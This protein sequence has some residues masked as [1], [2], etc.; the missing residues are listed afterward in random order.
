MNLQN[1]NIARIRWALLGIVVLV[2]M[3]YAM[4]GFGFYGYVQSWGGVVFKAICGGCIGWFISR[5]VIGL[6][7]SELPAEQRPMAGL[8]LAVLIGFFAHALSTGA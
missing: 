5:Y 7:I 6:D 4:V 8:S 2:G 3:H 1:L